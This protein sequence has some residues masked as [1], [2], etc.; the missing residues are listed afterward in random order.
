[1]HLAQCRIAGV[2]MGL[3]EGCRPGRHQRGWRTHGHVDAPHGG[4]YQRRGL[5]CGGGHLAQ[6]ARKSGG[7]ST[8]SSRNFAPWACAFMASAAS[9][10]KTLMCPPTSALMASPPLQKIR[11]ACGGVSAS[12]AHQQ[13]GFHPI[14]AAQRAASPKHH[15]LVAVAQRLHQLRKRLKGA[16][17]VYSHHAVVSAQRGHPA[18]CVHRMRAKTALRNV[19]QRAA[20]EGHQGV[21][22]PAD[23]WP[24]GQKPRRQCRLG[25]S[26]CAVAQRRGAPWRWPGRPRCRSDQNRPRL[27][28]AMHSLPAQSCAVASCPT[29]SAESAPA[30]LRAVQRGGAEQRIPK[31][32]AWCWMQRCS[33]AGSR[34]VLL[35]WRLCGPGCTALVGGGLGPPHQG[36]QALATFPVLQA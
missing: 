11:S 1:M 4:P 36:Q 20:G 13:R 32:L 12:M 26:G 3:R 35:C 24:P 21:A 10:V 2:C 9:P 23:P 33:V 5:L 6:C 14:L 8:A 34:R 31:G 29:P 7:E 18:H 25:G 19:Q 17:G 28:G 27:E 16:L 15:P 22:N 30:R